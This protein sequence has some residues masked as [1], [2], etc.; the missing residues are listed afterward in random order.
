MTLTAKAD[1]FAPRVET[2]RLPEGAVKELEMVLEK[3]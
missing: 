1:G 3:K 2:L